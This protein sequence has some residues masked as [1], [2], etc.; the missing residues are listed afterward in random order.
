MRTAAL[1]LAVLLALAATGL[2]HPSVAAQGAIELRSEDVRNEF[3]NGIVFSMSVVAPSPVEEVRLRY[4][5]APDGT[6]AAGVADC[7]AAATTTC[8]FELRSTLRTFLIPGTEITYYWDIRDSAGNTLSTEPRLFVYEDTRF[9]WQTL[10]E[11]NLTVWWYAGS[12]EDAQ[13]VL[14]AARE[15]LDG[16]SRLVGTSVDF[17]VKVFSYASTDDMQ[18]AILSGSQQGIVTLGEVVYSDTAMVSADVYPLDIVRHEVA[19]IVVRQ[20]TKGPFDIPDWLNE[21]TAVYAQREPLAGEV[22]ALETAIRRNDV[23]SIHAMSSASLASTAGNVNLFYGQSWS[24][25]SFLVDNYGPDKFAQL[26]AVFKEG[27]T[28]DRALRGVY[29]FGQEELEARWRESVGL[30]PAMRPEPSPALEPSPAPEAQ[31]ATQEDGD[32]FPVV[33]VA[34]A[35]ILTILVA[36]VVLAGGLLLARRYR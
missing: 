26:F 10:S 27:S 35:A 11:D 17:P 5:I 13:A 2:V 25:V 14:A 31:P 33:G 34:V 23:F 7:T 28:T 4:S 32:S 22:Q 3:P 15:S 36:G 18:A 1:A 30:P 8:T 20:A 29:G 12:A 9:D 21:G 6:G 24:L 19:H 16:T